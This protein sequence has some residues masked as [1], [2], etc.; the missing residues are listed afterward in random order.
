MM[1]GDIKHF[2]LTIQ[3]MVVVFAVICAWHLLPKISD[4]FDPAPAFVMWLFISNMIRILL[5]PLIMVGQNL[6]SR[7]S[8]M[9][10]ESGVCHQPKVGEGNRDSSVASGAASGE[11]GTAG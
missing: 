4:R 10:T 2:H 9:R 7:H 11:P 5:M 8:E 3:G 1:A 6:L